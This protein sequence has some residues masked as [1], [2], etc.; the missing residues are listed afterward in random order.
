[1][2]P[3]GRIIVT[4]GEPSGVGGEL[5]IRAVAAGQGGLITIDDPARLKTLAG[6]MGAGI[7]IVPIDDLSAPAPIPSGSLAVQPI[8]WADEVVAGKPSPSNAPQIIQA[9]RDAVQAVSLG[10][11]EAIVT[12]PIQKSTLAEAGF[13]HA[14]HTEFLAE[15]DGLNKKPVMM[16]ANRYLRIVPLTIHT[17]LKN[18]F[19]LITTENLIQTAHIIDE[20]LR[21]D[22][23]VSHP[24][25]AV[26]GLNPHAGEDGMLGLEEKTIITPALS[27]LFAQGIDITGPYAA[28]SLFFAERLGDYDAVLAMYH[29]QALIPVK[30]LDFF[31]T[32]NIT[33]GLDMVR[34][35]PDHGTA[36]DQAGYFTAKP[37]SLIKAI[38]TARAIAEARRARR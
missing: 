10:T 37:D 12:N 6:V 26:C 1:M 38:E 7:S 2:I 25:I 36:L 16:L 20:A 11:A 21:N 17:P 35:S 33:L 3:A 31:G 13:A 5:L 29:D 18:V 4:P 8:T 22:M 32:V 30:T 23:A 27:S 9:I 24:R 19:S 28:D 14:G 15:L 34:T